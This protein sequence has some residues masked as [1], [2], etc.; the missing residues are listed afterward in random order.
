M[1]RWW[2]RSRLG[3]PGPSASTL[4]GALLIALTAAYLYERAPVLA[5]FYSNAPERLV[6]VNNL[7]RSHDVKF[8][9]RDDVRSCEDALM[10][11]SIG[12]AIVA[13]DPGR[14]RWNTVMGLF[15]PDPV[16]GADIYIY[17]YKSAS[18]PDSEALR[19]VELVGFPGGSDLHTLGMAFDEASSTLFVANHAKA[20][21]RIEVFKLEINALKATH[22]RTVSHP[23]I[24][25]PNSIAL[26]SSEE[27]FVTNDHAIPATRSK[28]LSVLE[29]YLAPPTGTVVY[30]DLRGAEVEA[31]VVARAPFANGM[32]I[33]NATTVAVA[34]SSRGAVYLYTLTPHPLPS[35]P[36]P[37][38]DKAAQK[39]TPELTYASR[40]KV[41]FVPDNLSLSRSKTG[42][43][44]LIIAGHA[45]APSLTHFAAT[46]HICND[47]AE[48]ARAD[49]ETASYC[50]AAT[51]PSWVSEWSEED[52]LRHLY[53]DTEYPSSATA[54]RDADRGVGIVAGLYAKG[55]LIW[56]E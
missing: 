3:G 2:N 1:P 9:D 48:L 53:V 12:V 39:R 6:R 4:L 16:P 10:V 38:D 31:D 29:T 25:G 7:G 50:E 40:I 37:N 41:P 54:A 46:R 49:P 5:T 20:G 42:K 45:H 56:R 55:L 36:Q 28:F 27:F 30:V 43:T 18:T 52:G 19:R 14:E 24:H 8:A 47:P 34:S 13:C 21:P 26:V 33:L 32:E 15:L 23:L 35:S 44:K 17:D 22:V 11:E 51:A